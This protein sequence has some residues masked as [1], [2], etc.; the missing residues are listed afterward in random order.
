MSLLS[1]LQEEILRAFFQHEQ[2][3]FLTGGAALAGFH[4]KHR[5]TADLDLFTTP[6]ALGEGGDLDAGDAG[7]KAA[8]QQI[9]ATIENIVTSPDFRRRLVRRGSEGVMVDLVIDRAAQGHPEKQRMGEI[10]VDLPEEILANKLCT[11]LSRSE[12]RD[13]V[14]VYALQRAGFSLEQALPVAARKDGGL[15]PANLAWLL[16]QIEIGD[17]ARIP[18][19]IQPAELRAAIADWVALLTRLA[20]PGTDGGPPRSGP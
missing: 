19:G 6:S 13:L 15:T 10:R 3:F 20:H 17:D 4:L 8:A 11:L 1:P 12:P 14:D 5:R 18:G 2:R 16:A 9:G 7:L